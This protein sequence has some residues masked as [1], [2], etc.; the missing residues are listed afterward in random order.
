[1]STCQKICSEK[2]KMRASKIQ[3]ENDFT[4]TTNQNCVSP[5]FGVEEQKLNL[6]V[7]HYAEK[8]VIA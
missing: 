7:G 8:C 3:A 5:S 2:I 1:M 6:V 4:H